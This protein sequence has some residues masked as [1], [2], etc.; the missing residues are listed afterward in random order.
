MVRRRNKVRKN[1]SLKKSASRRRDQKNS[2]R[3]R[4]FRWTLVIVLVAIGMVG[5]WG[6]ERVESLA[7]NWTTVQH[8]SIVGLKQ[9][10]REEVLSE[11]ELLPET[12][13]FQIQPESM[14]A[15]LES[16]PWIRTASIERVFPHTLAIRIVERE[17]AAIWKSS[18]GTYL[19]D[20]QAHIL[21]RL[22]DSESSGFPLLVGLSSDYSDSSDQGR[23]QQVQHGIQVGRLLS[24]AFNAVPTVNV[25]SDSV[26][27]ADIHKLRFQFGDSIE[28]QWQRFQALYPSIRTQ[29]SRE[30]I[31]VDLRYSGKVILRK[32]E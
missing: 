25:K 24:S 4:I 13:L 27:V 14:I 19:L 29:I 26:I 12:S 28:E 7:M 17:A 22:E 8:V 21:P 1:Q 5:V 23:R 15:H 18:K 9:L 31:E 32:R 11:L 10:Q 30:T 2:L 6:F 3:K 16:H 20:D